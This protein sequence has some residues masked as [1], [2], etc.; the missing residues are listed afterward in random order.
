MTWHPHANRFKTFALLVGMSALIVFVGSLFGKTAMFLAVLFA[1]GMNVY[2]Y[3]N[4][5][6]LALRAMHAQPVSELQAPA[7]YRIVRELA[8]AAHQ[9]MPRLYISDTNAPNAFATGRNPRNAAVCCTTG[10]LGILTERELRAV[11]GHELS[12]VYNR[13]I[14]ISCIAGAMASVITA[15][16]N[17]AM[18]AGMFGGNSRDGENPFALLLVSLLGPIAATVV[19]LAV[20]RSR[21]YQ[22]DESGAVLTGDPLAL[23]SAL[24]KISGGVQAAPLPPEP[25]LASQAHLMIASPF[26]AGERIGSLFSTHPPIEDRIRR[27]EQMAGR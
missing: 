19:R 25:Q 23:A 10:I 17:M 5:D 2:T 24:R 9:P 16:A 22:A 7:M 14:L 18:F 6:K 12:H 13:D 15:L 21:E 8:T 3:Y 27:L 11:L 26:R 20:S 4:S 1:I